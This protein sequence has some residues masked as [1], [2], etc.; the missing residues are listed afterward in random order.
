MQA[1]DVTSYARSLLSEP[2]NG[3]WLTESRA[4]QF[5]DRAHKIIVRSL[6]WPESRFVFSTQPTVQEYQLSEVIRILRVYVAGQPVVRT[7][8]PTLQ[9]QQWQFDDQTGTVGGPGGYV[10]PGQAPVLVGNQYTPQWTSQPATAYPVA[11]SLG[12]PSPS[13]APWMAGMRPRYYTRG[14]NLGLVPAPLGTYQVVC[15]VIAQ[16]VT[17][18]SD[19][20]TLVL[21][22]IALDAVAWKVCELAY[23]AD[24]D[25]QGAGD[26]RNYA[27]TEFNT[28][29]KELKAWR[30]EYDGMGPRGPNVL[31]NRSFYRKGNN[32]LG[33]GWG[34]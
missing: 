3:Q 33:S 29:M 5:V 1:Q 15:D 12:Y 26:S 2:T 6:K 19:T 34:N 23:F 22:D 7:D 32:R 13:A 30:R 4:I 31:T 11:S 21:P 17:L 10:A 8:I 16:P 18:V 25:N 20:D 27:Q 9:G 28:A 14:G 24:R